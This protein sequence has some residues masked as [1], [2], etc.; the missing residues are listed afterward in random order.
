V[1][2]AAYDPIAM[3]AARPL[4]PA[5]VR[6]AASLDDVLGDVDAV[7]LVTRWAEFQRLPDLLQGRAKQP[8]VIDG[9]RVLKAETLARYDGIGR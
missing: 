4:L 5:G 6:Y 3:P 8:V 1:Q 2:V 7:L 9:R